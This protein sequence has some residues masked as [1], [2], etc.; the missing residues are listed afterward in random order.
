M[1]HTSQAMVVPTTGT[2][3]L[4]RGATKF[5]NV[6]VTVAGTGTVSFYEGYPPGNVNVTGGAFQGNIGG[7]THGTPQ[8]Y[9][10]IFTVNAAATGVTAVNLEVQGPIIAGGVTGATTL[11]IDYN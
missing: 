4:V 11:T 1:I 10:P 9:V 6:N 2:I 5:F 3:E 8:G 7:L